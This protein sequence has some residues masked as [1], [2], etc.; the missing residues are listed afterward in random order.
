MNSFFIPASVCPEDFTFIVD[1]T[2]YYCHK[3]VLIN[4][5]MVVSQNI[6]ADPTFS[7]MEIPNIKDPNHHFQL[8]IDYFHGKQLK[9]TEQ[10][11]PL[12]AYITTYLQ[13]MS[14]FPEISNSPMTLSKETAIQN[15]KSCAELGNS[16]PD[17][18]K[19]I[20][21]SWAEFSKNE[22]IYSLPVF[23]FAQIFNSDEFSVD[24]ESELFNFILE[25]IKRNSNEYAALFEY[26]YANKLQQEDINKLL[27]MD[28]IDNVNPEIINLLLDKIDPLPED[29]QN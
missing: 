27:E 28:Q 4:L 24:N 8:I 20:A 16:S 9:I 7:V 6:L 25:L 19:I 18:A 15:L 5:S 12:I 14:L 3:F 11:Y 23:A 22:D 10:N 13:I 1:G 2:K 26:C 29:V 21:S 17:F